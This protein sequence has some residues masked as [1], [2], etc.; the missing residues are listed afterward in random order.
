MNAMTGFNAATGSIDL[1]A[2]RNHQSRKQHHDACGNENPCDTAKAENHA[3][4]SGT[5]CDG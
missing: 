5:G 4:H 1:N 2:K 3:A